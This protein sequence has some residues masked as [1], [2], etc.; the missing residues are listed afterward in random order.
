MANYLKRYNYIDLVESVFCIQEKKSP[1]LRGLFSIPNIWDP[2]NGGFNSRPKSSTKLV[3]LT[4]IG[5][6]GSCDPKNALRKRFLQVSPPPA[7]QTSGYLAIAIR[8]PDINAQY[9]DQGGRS[10]ASNSTRI[11]TLV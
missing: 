3:I 2:M 7:R 5:G 9:A 8:R 1:V 6:F 11:S 4:H 10:L